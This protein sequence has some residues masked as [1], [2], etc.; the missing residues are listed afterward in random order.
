MCRTHI[1]KQVLQQCATRFL[2]ASSD[3][4]HGA[5]APVERTVWVDVEDN[6]TY[7]FGMDI[8]SGICILGGVTR[9]WYTVTDD[10][11]TDGPERAVRCSW[12]REGAT[13]RSM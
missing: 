11:E 12:S 2:P 8:V 13:D 1:S 4:V 7:G 6:E 10:V 5:L 3:A 9:G